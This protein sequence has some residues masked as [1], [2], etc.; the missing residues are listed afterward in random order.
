MTCPIDGLDLVNNMVIY[1]DEGWHKIRQNTEIIMQYTGFE[2]KNGVE[3][4]EGDC[5]GHRG[6][7]VG[8]YADT[9][10]INGDTPLSIV[11]SKQVVVGNVYEK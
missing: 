11:A 10:C 8:Y 6:N 5:L 3:I 7:V 1:A 9:F 2:D 4:Y